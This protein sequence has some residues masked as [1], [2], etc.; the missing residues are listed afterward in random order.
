MRFKFIDNSRSQLWSV[1]PVKVAIFIVLAFSFAGTVRAE[2]FVFAG[3][4]A[5]YTFYDTLNDIKLTNDRTSNTGLDLVGA[6]GTEDYGLGL[7]YTTST[8]SV[9][10][11]VSG[12]RME[13]NLQGPGIVFSMIRRNPSDSKVLFYIGVESLKMTTKTSKCVDSIVCDKLEKDLSD[14]RAQTIVL[15]IIDTSEIGLGIG[16][17]GRIYQSDVIDRAYDINLMIGVGF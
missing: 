13:N 4:H 3:G 5:G 8:H 6:F 9:K 16:L 12:V 17:T 15:G 1:G 2:Y 14:N 11:E 7:T 10:D